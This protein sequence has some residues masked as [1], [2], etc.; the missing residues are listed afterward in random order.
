MR[1]KANVED[2]N[3]SYNSIEYDPDEHSYLRAEGDVEELGLEDPYAEIAEQR[4]EAFN[5]RHSTSGETEG[6]LDEWDSL[7]ASLYEGA[8]EDCDRRYEAKVE[9]QLQEFEA[10]E[11][12]T[13]DGSLTFT[14][15]APLSAIVDVEVGDRS[16]TDLWSELTET[17]SFIEA[18]IESVR[19]SATGKSPNEYREELVGRDL[20][21]TYPELAVRIGK[22]DRVALW[23]LVDD[24]QT[25]GQGTSPTEEI[26]HALE[27]LAGSGRTPTVAVRLDREFF[28]RVADQRRGVLSIIAALARGCDVRVVTTMGVRRKLARKHRQDLP[29]VSEICSTGRPGQSTDATVEQA[30]LEL[31]H[32][33]REVAILRQ[34]SGEASETLPKHAIESSAGVSSSRIRQCVGRLSDLDL[35]ATFE[36]ADGPHVELLKA[37]SAFVDRLDAEIGRQATLDSCVSDSGKSSIYCRV[38]TQRDGGGEDTPTTAATGPADRRRH[39]AAV[40]VEYMPR[41]RGAAVAASATEGAVSLVDHPVEPSDELRQPYLSYDGDD[42]L[43]AGAE[44]RNPMQYTVCVARALT[45]RRVFRDVLTP[46][47]LDGDVGDLGGLATDDPRILRDARCLGWLSDRDT[48]AERY[49]EALMAAEDELLDMTRQWH[50]GDYSCTPEEF[51]SRIT[52]FSHGII[53]TVAHLCDLADVE[54][55]REVRVPEF[56]RRFDADDRADLAKNVVH[57]AQIASRHGHFAAYRQLF[58]ADEDKRAAAMEPSIP[59]DDPSGDMI[60]SFVIVGSSIS[61]LADDLRAEIRRGADGADSRL[62]EDAPEFDVPVSITTDVGRPAMALTA[63][64]RLAQKNLSATRES[65]ALFDALAGSPLDAAAAIDYA[66]QSEDRPR[67]IRLDEV[68]RALAQLPSDRLLPTMQPTVQKL[69]KALL[70]V[71]SPLTQSEL[72]GRADVSSR[73]VRTHL[74]RLEALGLADSDEAGIRFALPFPTSDERGSDIVPGIATETGAD[75]VDVLYDLAEAISGEAAHDSEHPVGAAFFSEDW[76][77][78]LGQFAVYERWIDLAGR[79]SHR[80]L[81]PETRTVRFGRQS[82]QV[83]IQEVAA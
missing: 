78:A 74:P 22:G 2:A 41:W 45:D 42:R 69:T 68:R 55:V 15:Q 40:T 30:G 10:G 57:G 43:V 33:S 14:D 75:P 27:L 70:T 56:T 51:R 81:E 38:S 35:V 12:I 58:E 60:G 73:S 67:D 49:A 83:A 28:D 21:D 11:P 66:L 26:G 76:A 4:L 65:I 46:D 32:D 82:D 6:A 13:G 77:G 52:R 61:R 5:E 48:T 62:H 16:P 20:P 7:Y 36:T 50:N 72:A 53:G 47:R 54:L 34:L 63:R 71:E 44:Y 31:S 79:L 17:G 80:G 23:Q 59:A 37:G 18:I 25:L 8:F 9:E 29:G 1:G 19:V 64:D 39:G 3:K 24:L